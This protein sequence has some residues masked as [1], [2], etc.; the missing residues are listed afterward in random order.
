[1]AVTIVL[2]L[3]TLGG[4][5][6]NRDYP[7]S[8]AQPKVAEASTILTVACCCCRFDHTNLCQWKDSL[9]EY[10]TLFS[11]FEQLLG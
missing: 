8:V 3:A 10:E 1:M 2:A 9:M 7:I 4:K 11:F 5:T 6:K